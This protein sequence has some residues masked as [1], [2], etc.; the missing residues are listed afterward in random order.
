MNETNEK[1]FNL[2]TMCRKA[3]RMA[4][5]FDQVKESAEKKKAQL[6]LLASDISAKTEKEIRYYADKYGIPAERTALSISEFGL[7]IGKKVGV[8]AVCDEGFAKKTAELIAAADDT[9]A[10]SDTRE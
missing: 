8:I 2:L 4:L 3:G 10:R 9:A 5:G 6:I 1:L 7:G